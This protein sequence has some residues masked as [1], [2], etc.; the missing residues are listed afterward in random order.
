MP[1]ELTVAVHRHHQEEFWSKHSV[2]SNIVLI[3]NRLLKR[4]NIGDAVETEI[5]Q[6]TLELLSLDEDMLSAALNDIQSESETLDMMA[7]QLVA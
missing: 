7:K 1:D 4:S 2:Y 6:A 5:P 3:T